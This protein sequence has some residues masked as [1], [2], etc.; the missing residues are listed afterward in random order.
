MVPGLA[1]GKLYAV[2]L[3]VLLNNRSHVPGGRE[4]DEPSFILPRELAELDATAET[5]FPQFAH[6]RQTTST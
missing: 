1:I 2:S 6:S 4:A 5:S 3:L